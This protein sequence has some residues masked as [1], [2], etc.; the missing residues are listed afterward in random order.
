L[1][2]FTLK[3]WFYPEERPDGTFWCCVD[4]STHD[5]LEQAR[6]KLGGLVTAITGYMPDEVRFDEVS[7]K[8]G[9]HGQVY[10]EEVDEMMEYRIA[11]DTV[12]SPS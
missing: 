4:E 5:T 11:F 12:Q 10:V 9:I 3:F 6:E 7:A 1:D 2:V 8:A